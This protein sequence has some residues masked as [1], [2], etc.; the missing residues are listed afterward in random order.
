V[1][2]PYDS[3]V[4]GST[5]GHY[6]VLERLGEGG[7]GEV[8]LVEDL[9][10]QRKAALKLVSAHL[11]RDES[12]RQRFIQEARLAASVD[13]P[14]IAAIHDIGEV[15][16]R[17]Y[18][19]MEYVEGRSLREVLRA[20][21]V[22]L[23][24]ALDYAIE[25]SD[26]LAKVHDKG[27]I[28]RDLKPE[29]L[30]IANE[31][32]LKIIDFGLAKLADPV[33]QSGL[34]DAVTREGPVRTAEGVVMGTIGYMSPEQVRGE[35]IDARSDVFS[36][37]AVL[38]EMTTGTP[39][40]RRKT[41]A[42]TMSAILNEAPV[43]PHLDDVPTSAELQRVLRKCLAKDPATRYQGMRDLV[44]DLRQLRESLTSSDTVVRSGATTHG[45]GRRRGPLW[46]AVALAAAVVGGGALWF[47]TSRRAEPESSPASSG[48]PS[49]AVV[50]F[51]M[52]GGSP[53]NAWL[54]KGL[55]S[56]VITG[57]AQTPD[58]EVVGIE[59]LGDA[60]RQIG[61]ATLDAVGRE[62]FADLARRAG[63]RFILNG[64]IVQAASELR[65]D[66]RVEDLS[67]GVVR[68]ADSVRGA[69]VLVLA[70][71][72]AA[73]VRDGLD[74][75]TEPGS[76]RR[77]AEV[78]SAS[79]E[80]FRAYTAGLEAAANNRAGDA[81]KL[82]EQA[83]ALD[84]NFGLAYF[85]QS[86]VA[87]F[88]GRMTEY[89]RLLQLAARHIDRMP[90]RDAMLVRAVVAREAGQHEEARRLLE[91]IVDRYPDTALAWMFLTPLVADEDTSGRVNV[92]GRA[93][94]A[95]PYSPVLRNLNGYALLEAER[96]DEAIREFETYVKLRPTEANALDSLAEGQLVAGRVPEALV[97]YE[98]AIEGGYN[99]ARSGR[100]WALAIAGRYPEALAAL[101][102]ISNYRV[103]FLSRLGRYRDFA[104]ERAHVEQRAATQ[105][106][107][108]MQAAVHAVSAMS[109]IERRDCSNTTHIA[110]AE[111]ALANIPTEDRRPLQVVTHALAGICET[112]EG[113]LDGA[114]RRLGQ[115]RELH[116]AGRPHEKYWVRA[117]EGEI[118]LASGDPAAAAQ[119]FAAA[120]PAR[121]MYFNRGP[122]VA[123]P[124]TFLAN[125]F[126]SR[127]GPARVAIARGRPDEAIV[128]YRALLTPGPQSKWTAMLEPRYVLA[129]AR[130]LEK[131]GEREAARTEYHRFLD[132]WKEAD[133]GL[134]ELAEARARVSALAH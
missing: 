41:P 51:E 60:A 95:L 36:F 91:S 4:V 87:F 30:I 114:R 81:S 133:A 42:D 47:A 116:A 11:T 19:A 70:D 65:I 45:P 90:E 120:E 57:L 48:R 126:V 76:V 110:S 112:L 1:R 128:I 53:E 79:T 78:A 93:V 124:L 117:L 104:A 28:H 73:R 9:R 58:V 64:T 96:I 38:Y 26:A 7:M 3:G 106:N 22:K 35:T 27:V 8:F 17:T 31:G 68:F 37:G 10:L 131:T 61:A 122:G 105:G 72:L 111:R 107:T 82:F 100:A 113:R 62:K 123:P 14:H 46:A 89:R 32:Y 29:N 20:G 127:D 121:K 85:H 21:Q 83:T 18:I 115:A 94:A 71:Q 49:I 25:A 134:P 2:I 84:P 66:A 12:R 80:A 86:G 130:L 92:M 15:D 44:V 119:A 54:G 132:L 33:A 34:A 98:K 69:D 108:A 88:Q 50:T 56:M 6:R 59:R 63:A 52:M 103:F 97:T 23:R 109:A 40:F 101:P 55:P 43:P 75:Q 16:G 99:G 67:T 13:H 125:N 102:E 74:V 77:V 24:Q 118:A 5:I 39:P 129:L